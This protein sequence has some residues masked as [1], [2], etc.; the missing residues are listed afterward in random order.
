[1]FAPG[2]FKL[3]KWKASHRVMEQ[4]IAQHLRDQQP[5]CQIK[6]SKNYTK[7]LGLVWD[8]ITDTFRPMVSSAC[9]AGRLTKR[10]L[11]SGIAKLFDTL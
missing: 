2:G 5:L 7:V 1:M 11:L 6:Y 4:N 3:R 9:E 8:T 10:P